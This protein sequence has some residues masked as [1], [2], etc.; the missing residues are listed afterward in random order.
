MLKKHHRF[1]LRQATASMRELPDFLIIG[2]QKCG[3]TSLYNYLIQHPSISPSFEKEVRYFNN[4]YEKGVNWYRAHFP[5]KMHSA[6]MSWRHGT[7]QLTGEGEPSYLPNPVAPQRVLDLRPDARLIVML[8]NPVDRAYSHYQHR[9]TRNRETRAFEEVVRTD[10]ETLKD[11]WDGLP[12]GDFKRLGNFH[13]SYLPRG[14]YVNQIEAWMAVFPK[15]QF[16]FIKAE[17][18]FADRQNVFDDVLSFL[19]LPGY[20][21]EQSKRH[22]MGSYTQPMSIE[23]REDLLEYFRPHNQRLQETLGWDGTWES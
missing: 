12:K 22:N 14:F 7:R 4:H 6:L 2:A 19:R 8:R 5:T 17:D 16:L 9:F 11:G 3:T 23:L 18:F 1:L 15:E 13:Y 10:K 21:L 20:R